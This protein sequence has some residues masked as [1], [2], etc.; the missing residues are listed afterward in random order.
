MTTFFLLALSAVAV[1]FVLWP[2][3]GGKRDRW[4]FSDEDTPIG[5][6]ATRREVLVGNLSDLDFEFAMGKVSEEDYMSLRNSLKRQTLKIMEQMD[7]LN[8]GRPTAVKKADAS[9]PSC[10]SC[11]G[12]A[13]R[14]AR[15]CPNCGSPLE[16]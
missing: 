14:G 10:A 11:G 3:L 12:A 7:V 13:P 16:G 1:L 9:T 4:E 2:V 8:A 6:L 5:R 15:F